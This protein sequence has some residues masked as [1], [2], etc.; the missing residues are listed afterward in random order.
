MTVNDIYGGSVG[1]LLHKDIIASCLGK[2][3][4]MEDISDIK[5]NRS[6]SIKMCFKV[7]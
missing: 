6:F 3:G 1:D 2:V 7:F 5:V 4:K